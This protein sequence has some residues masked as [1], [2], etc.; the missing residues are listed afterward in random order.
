MKE[1]DLKKI[2]KIGYERI[3]ILMNLAE[4]EAKRGNWDRVKRYVYLARKIAMK[5][6]LRF[7]KKWKRRICK[8]C[9]TLLVYGKNARVRV[10]AKR[11]PHVVI[12]CLECNHIYR[13]PMIREKKEK[14]KK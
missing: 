3:D 9:G 7:P 10:K 6:R 2:K 13:I 1:K 8:K 5:L 4:E 14:R 11:Y 12:T